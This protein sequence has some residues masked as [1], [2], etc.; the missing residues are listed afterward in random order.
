LEKLKQLQKRLAQQVV[1]LEKGPTFATNDC[2]FGIDIQYEG[3]EAYV[4]IAVY[5]FDG[6]W[7]ETYVSQQ[8][9]GMPYVPSY[10]CFR[11]GPPIL[12]AIEW[13][14]QKTPWQP[15]L[16][17]IDGHGLAHPRQFGVAC[18][19]G[20]QLDT[21]TIGVAKRPL[22]KYSGTLASQRGATLLLKQAQ[23]SVGCVLRTQTATKPVYVSVGHGCS[24]EQAVAITLQF[25]P[26]YKLAN[27]IR[28]ADQAARQLAKGR[29]VL[30]AVVLG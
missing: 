3:E 6:Q 17:M 8:Q 23:Q 27:P 2:L 19:I 14:Q 12:A 7:Q 20:V 29:E 28:R 26:D 16:L 25:S 24:L 22:L 9:A 21:P 5:T 4:A 13:I 10:F 30:E 18:Y 11:E 15:S 1:V